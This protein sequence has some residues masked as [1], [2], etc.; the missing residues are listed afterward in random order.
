MVIV[1][2]FSEVTLLYTWNLP[3][4]AG[5]GTAHALSILGKSYTYRNYGNEMVDLSRENQLFE[6]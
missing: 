3:W 2:C 6:Y 5:E 4:G 1:I